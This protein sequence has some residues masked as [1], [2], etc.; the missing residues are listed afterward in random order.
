MTLTPVPIHTLD[1][2][3]ALNQV[4]PNIFNTCIA[5][6]KGVPIE[7]W[8]LILGVLILSRFLKR[9][10][11]RPDSKRNIEQKTYEN[12]NWLKGRD[13][14][15]TIRELSPTEFE[16]FICDLFEQLGFSTTHTG[17]SHDGGVDVVAEK[18]GVKYYIQ[19]KK[20]I[21]R[22]VTLGALRDFY[23][24]LVDHLANGVGYFIT[25]NKFTLEAKKFAE[26]KPIE[27]I[28]GY[29]LLE[30]MK[31]VEQKT[32]TEYYFDNQ[33]KK[34]NIGIVNQEDSHINKTNNYKKCPRCGGELVER[35]SK[36]GKFYGCSNFPKCWYKSSVI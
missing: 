36:Y 25:T 34:S 12:K 10:K 17:K 35:E 16:L 19:C 4:I 28:D 24:S 9:K 11:K 13:T 29:R 31:M 21:T 5:V 23:G 8:L 27:L 32:N 33:A 1:F 20:F 3:N 18:N 26:D 30:Y 15:G 6:L 2:S 7:I 22:E 14:L